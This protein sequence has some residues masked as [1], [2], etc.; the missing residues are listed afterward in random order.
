MNFDDSNMFEEPAPRRD[1]IE[2]QVDVPHEVYVKWPLYL[3]LVI[4]AVIVGEIVVNI[5]LTLRPVEQET[6]VLSADNFTID[7]DLSVGGSVTLGGTIKVDKVSTTDTIITQH[8]KTEE[9]NFQT[10]SNG[11]C[12]LNAALFTYYTPI[13][14]PVIRDL[15]QTTHDVPVTWTEIPLKVDGLT[16]QGNTL[17]W[18]DLAAGTAIPFSYWWVNV[19]IQPTIKVTTVYF[20]FSLEVQNDDLSKSLLVDQIDTQTVGGSDFLGM[21][22]LQGIIGTPCH[23]L[24]RSLV[25]KVTLRGQCMTTSTATTMSYQAFDCTIARLA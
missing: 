14:P 16:S 9:L 21:Y 22:Q 3:V 4:L 17:V 6:K 19:R 20:R 23:S 11:L 10:V 2:K 15:K 8:L 5:L 1:A 13:V 25:T 7:G 18:Y 12:T 24:D